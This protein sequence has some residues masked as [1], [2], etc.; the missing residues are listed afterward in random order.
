M[1]GRM[2]QSS[3]FYTFDRKYK[4]M[5]SVNLISHV[6]STILRNMSDCL[7]A[8]FFSINKFICSSSR[9]KTIYDLLFIFIIIFTMINHMISCIC[10][11]CYFLE[12]AQFYLD[13]N[14]D[15][16]YE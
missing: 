1:N 4:Y 3:M 11:F 9:P 5:E 13:D 10:S 2:L 7:F 6:L 8:A 14:V 15:E 12:Y 16:E